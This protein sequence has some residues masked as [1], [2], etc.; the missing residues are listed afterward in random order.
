MIGMD[1]LALTASGPFRGDVTVCADV[2]DRLAREEL[3]Q[4]L[5]PPVLIETSGAA[6]AIYRQSRG[7]VRYCQENALAATTLISSD[8]VVPE[9][10]RT[11]AIAAWP[12]DFD[13]LSQLA[14]EVRRLGIPWGIVVPL[15]YPLTTEESNLARLADL[16]AFNE[17]AFL[18]A[19][20]IELEP[21][22]KQAIASSED[23]VLDDTAYSQLFHGDL[24]STTLAIESHVAALAHERKLSDFVIPPDWTETTNWN[25][26][27]VL[28]LA[29]TRLIRMKK[30][31]ELGWKLIRSAQQLALLDKPIARVA[32][33]IGLA[34]LPGIDAVSREI[35]ESWLV[36]GESE[37]LTSLQSRW[38]SLPS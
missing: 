26:A 8:G 6:E 18:T 1:Y 37:F 24:D 33:A 31:V 11:L 30:D 34:G 5:R 25:G 10:S 32:E 23:R 19:V 27:V 29:A 36:G 28:T 22:A 17:A 12:M 3:V 14:A 35:L 20:T 21:S 4:T 38:R 9:E 7:G 16:A 2:Y 13:R 15:I